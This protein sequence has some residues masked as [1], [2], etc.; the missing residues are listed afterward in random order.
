M[1]EIRYCGLTTAPQRLVVTGM[2]SGANDGWQIVHVLPAQSMPNGAR[3][4]AIAVQGQFSHRQTNGTGILRGMFQ[5]CLGR[6]DGTRYPHYRASHTI[7]LPLGVD[8]GIP[9]QFLVLITSGLPD[10]GIGGSIDPAAGELC[11]WARSTWNGDPQTYQAGFDVEG[12][13]WLWWDLTAIPSGHATWGRYL[14]A[15]PV[16]LPSVP[17]LAVVTSGAFGGDGETWLAFQNVWYE[18]RGYNQPAPQFAMGQAADGTVGTFLARIGSTGW[19]MSRV[20]PFVSVDTLAEVGQVQQGGFWTIP[21]TGTATRMI[22]G[23]WAPAPGVVWIRRAHWFAVRIDTLEDMR[24]ASFATTP[25]GGPMTGEAWRATSLT[26]ERPAAGTLVEPIVMAHGVARLPVG[27]FGGMGVRVLEQQEGSW[28]GATAAPQIEPARGEGCSSMAFGRRLFQV[29]SPA[30]QWRLAQA[31]SAGAP[32]SPQPM[33]DGEIVAFHPVRDPEH[34]TTPPGGLPSPIVLVPDR[35]APDVGS[36]PEPP[37]RPAAARSQRARNER[38][39]IRGATGYRRSWPLGA[40]VLREL[41][42]QW[43]PMPRAEGEAVFDF[44]RANQVWAYL[45]PA[46]DLA[47]VGNLTNPELAAVDHRNVTVSIDVAL[48]TWTGP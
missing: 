21:T 14:P 46:G 4:Y 13:S 48:L 38:P 1:T 22:I 36:L 7:G 44:L 30:I 18:P 34:I 15:G 2:G 24:R 10:V 6:T 31:G 47:A 29:G 5:V 16:V 35:Q 17:G 20:P 27:A 11:I 12:L 28:F 43:G 32:P 25:L 45:P 41:S 19:G 33:A 37:H 3:Q 26:L 8:D 39:A 9:W 42:L 23:A 40:S